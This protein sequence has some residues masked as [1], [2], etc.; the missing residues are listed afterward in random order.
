MPAPD[1][2]WVGDAETSS[3]TVGSG[4]GIRVSS[5][6]MPKIALFSSV[7]LHSLLAILAWLCLVGTRLLN[8]NVMLG[9]RMRC[10]NTCLSD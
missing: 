10:G 1:G 3:R 7:S 6:G 2:W 9:L 8:Y 4:L 5:S